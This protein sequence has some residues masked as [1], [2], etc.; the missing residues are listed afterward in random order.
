MAD[1]TVTP[2]EHDPFAEPASAIAPRRKFGVGVDPVGALG[3]LLAA[4]APWEGEKLAGALTKALTLPGRALADPGSFGSNVSLNGQPSAADRALMDEAASF[5][6]VIPMG[7]LALPKPSGSL[8]IFGGFMA[9]TADLPALKGAQALEQ[10]LAH[11]TS[12]SV[13][14]KKSKILSQT[15]WYRGPDEKWRFEIPD[16]NADLDLRDVVSGSSPVPL[17]T[18]I[19]HPKLFSAYPHLR[20]ISVRGIDSKDFLGQYDP[21]GKNENIAIA[22]DIGTAAKSPLTI[23]LHEI[24]HAVQNREG[25]ANGAAPGDPQINTAYDKL[26]SRATSITESIQSDFTDWRREHGSGG[27]PDIEF[28]KFL[29]A[30]PSKA[31]LWRQIQVMNHRRTVQ[32]DQ[33]APYMHVAGEVEARNVENRFGRGAMFAPWATQD[34]PDWLQIIRTMK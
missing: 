23:M 28:R 17:D 18:V 21:Y 4:G 15:G 24:Q 27:D 25:F 9:K 2:V 6:S 3:S 26:F 34:T 11:D 1:F 10:E 8:G 20:D 30:N 12:L 13:L 22:G 16:T 29:E 7:Q 32:G 33:L 31:T 5:A 14:T 19:N